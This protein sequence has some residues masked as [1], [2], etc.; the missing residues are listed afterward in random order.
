MAVEIL[1]LIRD[2]LQE[3][4]SLLTENM[5]ENCN[6][7]MRRLGVL[8]EEAMRCDSIDIGIVEELNRAKNQLISES[9]WS[10]RHC[11]YQ[12]PLETNARRGRP[13]FFISEEQLC[14]FKANGFTQREMGEMLGVS[15][16]TIENRMA[17][18]NMT[19]ASRYSNIDDE[20]LDIYVQRIVGH[21]PRSGEKTIEGELRSLGVCVQ[22]R[23][24]R[25]SLKRVDPVG[26]RIRAMTV[27]QRRVYNVHSPLALWH[28]DG[29][30]KLIR[31]RFIVHGCVDGFSRVVVYLAL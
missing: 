7:C 4:D 24:L 12:A 23:R 10:E 14:F 26:R 1:I 5:Q 15:L 19:N 11:P 2:S 6:M 29:N 22:R 20:C 25:D 9:Q 13:K 17:E 21:F 3:I 8:A 16:R 18:Y 27:I 30:H 28:M 31:W